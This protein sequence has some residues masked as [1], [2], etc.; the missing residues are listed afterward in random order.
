MD[1]SQ[2]TL[3]KRPGAKRPLVILRPD[4]S[5]SFTFEEKDKS[6]A[7]EILRNLNTGTVWAPTFEEAAS[8]SLEDTDD[9]AASA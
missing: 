7:E 8:E 6:F 1:E 4:G 3:E 5:E 9:L 2:Y